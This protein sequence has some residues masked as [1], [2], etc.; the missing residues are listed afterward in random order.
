VCGNLAQTITIDPDWTL[1]EFLA[2]LAERAE[3]QLK[4]PSIRT[5]AKTLYVQAPK[6]LEEQTRPNLQKKMKALVSDGEE[7]GVSD[8][9][10]AISF[11]F[12]LVY[13]T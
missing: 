1:E 5:E 8:V 3:A 13:K 10:F 9:A 11:K 7:V 12:K 6:S 4:K 2:S